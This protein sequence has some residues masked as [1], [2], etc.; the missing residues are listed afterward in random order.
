CAASSRRAAPSAPAKRVGSSAAVGSKMPDGPMSPLETI[1][2]RRLDQATAS[3][4]GTDDALLRDRR[5]PSPVTRPE[6]PEN[7]GAPRAGD[8]ASA[9]EEHP[10][11]EAHGAVQPDGVIE[12]R[13]VPRAPHD[14]VRARGGTEKSPVAREDERG[15][16][17]ERVVRQDASRPD[18]QATTCRA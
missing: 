16:V 3:T 11:V 5:E 8:R 7:E 4:A 14:P 13:A 15:G 10:A 6:A 18:P 2:A 9:R 17:H 1:I 12:A